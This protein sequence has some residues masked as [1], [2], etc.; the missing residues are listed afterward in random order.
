MEWKEFLS[1]GVE[2]LFEGRPLVQL[3][4]K[5]GTCAQGRLMDADPFV[6]LES[7]M[8]EDEECKPTGRVWII[9]SAEMM[10]LKLIIPDMMPDTWNGFDEAVEE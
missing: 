5:D 2:D 10:A 9:G 3:F 6:I 1:K 7:N 4:L 8:R